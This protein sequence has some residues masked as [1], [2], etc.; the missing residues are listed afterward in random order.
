MN[1]EERAR[2]IIDVK[3]QQS[4]LVIVVYGLLEHNVA[5]LYRVVQMIDKENWESMSG[6]R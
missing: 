2:L 1:P 3:L 6:A 5:I 4:G